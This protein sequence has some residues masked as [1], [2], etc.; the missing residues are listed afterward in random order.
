MRK[1]GIRPTKDRKGKIADSGAYQG[2]KRR[3]IKMKRY[4]ILKE[5]KATENVNSAAL[6]NSLFQGALQPIFICLPADS[7]ASKGPSGVPLEVVSIV[8]L[9]LVG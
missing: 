2:W 1:S 3:S 8:T 9:S 7:L 5:K 4:K 6:R